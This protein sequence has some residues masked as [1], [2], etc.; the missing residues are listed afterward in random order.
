MEEVGT[1]HQNDR[2]VFQYRR[3]RRC[4]FAVRVI[5]REIPDTT[6]ANSLRKELAHS[7]VRNVPE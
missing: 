6:L 2:W 4:G 5:L 1:P 7:F 3:C